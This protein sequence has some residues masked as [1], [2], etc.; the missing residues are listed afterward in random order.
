M[1]I[2]RWL[3][4]GF[5]LIELMIVVAVIGILA[6][7]AYPSYQEYV[8][9][10]RRA[11]AQAALLELTQFMERFFTVNSRFVN[12]DNSQVV[13]PFTESPKDGGTKYYD[14]QFVA[15]TATTTTYTLEAVPKN[16]MAGDGCG[17]LRVNQAGVKSRTGSM[18]ADQC[19]RH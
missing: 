12:T 8:R 3:P 7:I 11:D 19:W 6:A 13:L 10:A 15:G 14:L 1:S 2:R 16:A 17:S 5:T 4:R 18:S 9:K